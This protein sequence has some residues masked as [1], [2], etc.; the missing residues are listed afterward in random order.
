VGVEIQS[1][2]S[3]LKFGNSLRRLCQ[4]VSCLFSSVGVACAFRPSLDP[5]ALRGNCR[6]Q[7][8]SLRGRPAESS[9]QTAVRFVGRSIFR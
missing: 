4:F 9:A 3:R 5:S 1:D 6:E 2:G 7:H 8:R